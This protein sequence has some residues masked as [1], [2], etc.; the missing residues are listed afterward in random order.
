MLYLYLEQDNSILFANSV[1]ILSNFCQGPFT[2]HQRGRIEK[3]RELRK[4]EKQ[5]NEEVD[6]MENLLFD[7]QKK[8]KD[9]EA[10]YF[11][12]YCLHIQS[13]IKTYVHY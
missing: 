7:L 10:K 11:L 3:D 6:E 2:Q 12:N 1:S 4:M 13:F 5:Y 8:I 9:L